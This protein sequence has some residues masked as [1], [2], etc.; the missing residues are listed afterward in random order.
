MDG[1]ENIPT[2]WLP[3]LPCEFGTY[4][5]TLLA[6]RTGLLLSCLA[7][8][9]WAGHA[10]FRGFLAAVV[11]PLLSSIA[12]CSALGSAQ[13]HVPQFGHLDS[14]SSRS[15]SSTFPVK[16]TVAGYRFLQFLHL[17]S[18]STLGMEERTSEPLDKCFRACESFSAMTPLPARS[19]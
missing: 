5:C 3:G 16:L 9:R 10:R 18:S 13:F 11:S 7:R 4:K 12:C 8:L 2:M 15:M 14:C 6:E 1:I 17:Y 19:Y